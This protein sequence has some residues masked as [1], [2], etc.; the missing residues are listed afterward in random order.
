MF[1]YKE[2]A[3]KILEEEK[4]P[5][6]YREILRR[7]L[8][9]GLIR[10]SKN[11]KTPGNTMNAVL[12][13]DMKRRG[14]KSPFVRHTP[15]VVALRKYKDAVPGSVELE[16]SGE[17]GIGSTS[18]GKAGEFMVMAELLFRGYNIFVPAV[19]EGMDMIVT[20]GQHASYIQ[21]KL[22]NKK[23]DRYGASFKIKSF[24]RN[25]GNDS[26]YVFVLRDGEETEFVILPY[27]DMQK[28]IALG[29]IKT[30]KGGY[31]T[32]SI[33]KHEGGL[34]LGSRN[35]MSLEHN[36]NNWKVIG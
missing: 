33:S 1:T 21:V 10:P 22:A 35:G 25:K 4:K 26:F 5:L 8:E 7:A 31:Y 18:K 14:K 3:V 19:D 36:R 9:R 28:N 16:H 20:K 23:S 32:V 12:T 30:T 29:N 27:S 6:H 15:G 17:P 11:A 24:E 34:F 2:A 13:A